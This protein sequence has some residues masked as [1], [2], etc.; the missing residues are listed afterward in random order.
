M[1]FFYTNTRARTLSATHLP[2]ASIE[3]N[4][5][6]G[7]RTMPIRA[8][9]EQRMSGENTVFFQRFPVENVRRRRAG[10]V[11]ARLIGTGCGA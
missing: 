10:T 7:G 11:A 6:F 9:I 5:L 8:L 3:R 4:C 2:R 1:I